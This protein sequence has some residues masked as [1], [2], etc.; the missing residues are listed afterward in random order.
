MYVSR[1]PPTSALL[2][3]TAPLP[4]SLIFLLLNY[5]Y[6]CLRLGTPHAVNPAR[7]TLPSAANPVPC[8][9][10]SCSLFCYLLLPRPELLRP[11][12]DA[13]L[14]LLLL[15]LALLPPPASPVTATSSFR[16]FSTVGVLLSF[17][18]V[19]RWC[20][21]ANTVAIHQ[22]CILSFF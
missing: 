4:V 7:F 16:R 6:R 21:V 19:G 8:S 10:T 9:S 12:L 13:C 14:P 17:S 2:L 18:I 11:L 1:F 3:S 5:C 20:S 15:L 22:H